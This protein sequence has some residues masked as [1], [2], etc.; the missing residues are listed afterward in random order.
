M[1]KR[2]SQQAM[3]IVEL[4]VA[5]GLLSVVLVTVMTL[6]AQLIR[7]TEK[8]SLLSAGTYF[9]EQVMAERIGAAEEALIVAANN[10]VAAFNPAVYEGEGNLSKADQ[11]ARTKF[12]YKVEAERID[13]GVA[14]DPGQMWFVKVEVRWW[15]DDTTTTD[16]ARSGYGNLSVKRSRL[17]Y[18]SRPN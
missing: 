1:R 3:T 5:C 14:S 2:L 10:S 11:E 7:N 4:L 16:P 9:A 12:L 15:S 8:N 6:F 13:P 18:V 17:V